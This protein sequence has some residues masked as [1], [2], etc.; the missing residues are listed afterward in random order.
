LCGSRRS[1]SGS[2]FGDRIN[3]CSVIIRSGRF[4]RDPCI[5]SSTRFKGLKEVADFH[6]CVLAAIRSMPFVAKPGRPPAAFERVMSFAAPSEPVPVQ[7][8]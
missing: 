8:I 2:R 5:C 7:R 4:Y 1:G 3:P 6:A